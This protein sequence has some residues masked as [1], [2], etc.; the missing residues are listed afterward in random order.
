MYT[1]LPLF[2]EVW[3]HAI[4]SSAGS[5]TPQG[6]ILRGLIPRRV[7]FCGVSNPAGKLRPRRTRRKCFESMSFSLKGHFSKIVCMYKLHYPRHIGSMLKEPS[8]W[9]IFL[10]SAGSDTPEQLWNSNI[11]RIGS[12]I[13]KC[14]R[15]WIRGPNGVNEKNQGPKISCYYTF[16]HDIVLC[17]WAAMSCRIPLF[18][19]CEQ[20]M[21][22][23]HSTITTLFV[24]CRGGLNTLFLWPGLYVYT[25][26]T[27][28]P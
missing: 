19:W 22:Y 1:T 17:C 14:S 12:R 6:L 4:L 16:K 11:T 25:R 13:L 5:D 24:S 26:C 21:Q 27:W 8:I 10:C 2:C 28:I 20:H 23:S 7:L 18:L 3:Y 15:V 9:K